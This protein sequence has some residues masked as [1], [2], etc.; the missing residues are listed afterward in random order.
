MITA[1]AHSHE[2]A[3]FAICPAGHSSTQD[4]EAEAAH[5]ARDFADRTNSAAGGAAAAAEAVRPSSAAAG[6]GDLK[7]LNALH[8]AASSLR[9]LIGVGGSSAQGA[10]LLSRHMDESATIC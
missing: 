2:Q 1:S 10:F 9:L 5:I 8:V 6:A 4:A 3:E 7:V